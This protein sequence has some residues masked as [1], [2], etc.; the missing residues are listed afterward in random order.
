MKKWFMILLAALLLC[1]PLAA[2][3]EDAEP[4]PPPPPEEP[5]FERLPD[6]YLP[7]EQRVLGDWYADYAGLAVTLTFSEDG[8]YILA[9][10]G[11]Q[12]QPGKWEVKDGL[13]VMDGD[14]EGALLFV[15]GTLRCYGPDM[16]FTREKPETYVPAE[17]LQ[18]AAEGSFDGYWKAQFVAVGD[19]TILA[20]ALGENTELYIEGVK[21]ALGG[22]RLGYAIRDL[23]F[24]N[25]ALVLNEDD[26]GLTLQ[27]QQDGMLRLT[28]AGPEPVVIYL[29][30]VEIPKADS[31][32]QPEP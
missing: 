20:D 12:P 28:V 8:A 13:I 18:D 19:G 17:I 25:G 9:A 1:M 32:V 5:E 2:W 27:L 10:P 22:D 26:A 30:R 11:I 31:A 24:E 16:F 23:V 6:T 14:E 29:M 3:A 15:N 21:A 7:I 4:T